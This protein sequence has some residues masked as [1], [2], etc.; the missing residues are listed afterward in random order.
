MNVSGA[1]EYLSS[2]SI[3]VAGVSVYVSG[4]SIYVSSASKYDGKCWRPDRVKNP[5]VFDPVDLV[6][7]FQ[8]ASRIL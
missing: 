8:F 5:L 3:Y 6:T 4:A 7:D 2:E 1:S